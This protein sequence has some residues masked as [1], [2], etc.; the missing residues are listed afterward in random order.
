M[1]CRA[2]HCDRVIATSVVRGAKAAETLSAEGFDGRL[3][4]A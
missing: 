3:V 2:S 1:R 4:A